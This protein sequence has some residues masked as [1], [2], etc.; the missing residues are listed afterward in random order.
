VQSH[1]SS[2]TLAEI[3]RDLYLG[4]RTGVLELDRDGEQKLIGFSR[5]LIHYAESGKE[6]EQLDRRLVQ[7]KLLSA[8]AIEE[9]RADG[10]SGSDLAKNLRNRGL[11]SREPLD[12]AM[13]EIIDSVVRSVFQWQGGSARFKDEE[14]I[15]GET[16]FDTDVLTTFEVILQGIFTMSDFDPIGEAMGGLDNKIRLRSPAPLPVERLTLSPSHGFILSRVDGKSP[17]SEVLSVLPQHEEALALRFL[18]GLLVMGVLEYD[19][20][21]GDGPFR[22]ANILRDHADRR[23]LERMQEQTIR[24]AYAQMRTQNPY[25]VLGVTPSASRSAIE[26]AYEEAK[27]L[28]S[29]DRLVT[30][31][32]DQFRSE[33]AVIESRLIEAYLRLT[34]AET[35]VSKKMR[36]RDSNDGVSA[37]DLLVRVEMDKTKSKVALEESK[38]VAGGYHDKALKAQRDGDFHNAIQYVKLAISYDPD[39]ARLYFL[40][41]ECQV[42]NPGP[43]WQHQAEQNFTRATELDPWNAAFWISLG[44]FY[45]KRGLKL[46]ARKQFEEALKLVPEHPEAS[47]ELASLGK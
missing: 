10:S 36:R 35:Q 4:E 14:E 24:Q 23:A 47:T 29:R 27:G 3:F 26:Q 31:V 17:V 25:E 18:F 44:R 42:R 6:H 28:F 19:P 21:P 7:D 13:K 33:L 22:V 32:R 39:D 16:A 15:G 46:R 34:Q 12:K 9:A 11:I 8:G 5:G 40:L 30:S 41:A 45:K 37:D 2:Q 20:P 38:K 43:R 1:F